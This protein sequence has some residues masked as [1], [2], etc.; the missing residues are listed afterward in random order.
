MNSREKC[1]N[2][3]ILTRIIH[4]IHSEVQYVFIN[5]IYMMIIVEIRMTDLGL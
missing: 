4:R 5:G 2:L 3:Q 1:Y